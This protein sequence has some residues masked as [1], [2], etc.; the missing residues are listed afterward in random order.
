VYGVQDRAEYVERLGGL[1]RLRADM[2]V[3][4]GVNYGF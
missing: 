3:C 2:R 1:E 4:E